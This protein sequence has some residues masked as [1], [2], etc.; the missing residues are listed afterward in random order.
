MIHE[1][2]RSFI[3]IVADRE[4]HSILGAHFMCEHATDMI[5][6]LTAAINNGMTA[7][8]LLTVMRPHPTFEEGVT[9]A[10]RGLCGLCSLELSDK[11]VF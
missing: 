5:S 6:E 1:A 9:E 8:A 10:L 11:K 2:P 3:K 4:N 7:E